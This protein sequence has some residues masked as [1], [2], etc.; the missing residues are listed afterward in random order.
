MKDPVISAATLP[1][2][3]WFISGDAGYL[4]TDNEWHHANMF[5]AY[6][7]EFIKLYYYKTLEDAQAAIDLWERTHP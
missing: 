5:P 3:G 2:N 6:S 4:C 1:E 7:A